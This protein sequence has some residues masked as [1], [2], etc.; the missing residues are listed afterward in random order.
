[1]RFKSI[2][3]VLMILM[4]SVLSACG[5]ESPTATPV[6]PTATTAAAVEPTA[7]TAQAAEP[8]ATTAMAAE[9]TATTATTSGG[10]SGGKQYVLVP[11]NLGNPYFDTANKG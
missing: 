5:T 11:K 1:M 4:V 9:P 2:A 6:A 3:L 8:T 10:T 7:T